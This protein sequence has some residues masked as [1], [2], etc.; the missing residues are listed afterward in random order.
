MYDTDKD[1]LIKLFEYKKEKTSILLS[2]F[3]YDNGPL[4]LGITRSYEKKDG[5]IG[6]SSSGRLSKDEVEFIKENIDEIIEIMK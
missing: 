6:Y 2:I 4:K 5:S 1:K 3:S